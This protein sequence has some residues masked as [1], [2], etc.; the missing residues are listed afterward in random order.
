MKTD[1]LYLIIAVL[2]LYITWRT[3]KMNKKYFESKQ[4]TS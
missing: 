2:S 4:I 1:T 3:Y